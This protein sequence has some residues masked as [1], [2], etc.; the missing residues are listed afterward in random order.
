MIEFAF[1]SAKFY[2]VWNLAFVPIWSITE[3]QLS[4]EQSPQSN[5]LTTHT[6]V[7]VWL[8]ETRCFAKARRRAPAKVLS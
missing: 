4:I 1:M 8:R 3:R 7:Q 2:M 6:E 5:I